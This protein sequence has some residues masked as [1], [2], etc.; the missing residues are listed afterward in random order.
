MVCDILLSSL[1]IASTLI[2]E[3]KDSDMLYINR[4]VV[5]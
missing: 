3:M 5:K 2:Y 1:S 4:K